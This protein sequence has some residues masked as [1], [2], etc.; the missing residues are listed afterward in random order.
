MA[1]HVQAVPPFAQ[2]VVA[3]VF[4]GFATPRPPQL[5]A[6]GPQVT[7]EREA[8]LH[9]PFIV[10]GGQG[11][12]ARPEAHPRRALRAVGGREAVRQVGY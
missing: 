1:V 8:E 7:L 5:E 4:A 12:P 6:S 11:T 10:V 9:P 2:L 3:G